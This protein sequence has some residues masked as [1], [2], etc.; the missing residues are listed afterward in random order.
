MA[1]T[2]KR[3]SQYTETIHAVHNAWCAA[4]GYPVRSYKPQAGRPKAASFKNLKSQASSLC[5]QTFPQ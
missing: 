5:C 2:R 3:K 4:N 1:S